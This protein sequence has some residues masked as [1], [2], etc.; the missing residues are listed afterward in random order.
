[1]NRDDLRWVWGCVL[2]VV[3]PSAVLHLATDPDRR[4]TGLTIAPFGW[5]RLLVAHLA[6][7]LPLGWLLAGRLLTAAGLRDVA[8]GMWVAAGVGGAGLAALVLPGV[9]EGLVVAEVGMVFALIL[10]TAI[11]VGLV[12]PWCLAFA[13]AEAPRLPP[14]LA[15]G[16]G[17]GLALVPC[18]V[19]TQAVITNRTE[20][21]QDRLERERLA[22]ARPVVLGLCEL[23]SDQPLGQSPPCQVLKNLNTILPRIERAV[24][25][26]LPPTA[27]PAARLQRATLLV[28][29]DR[30][31]EAA[32]LVA[33]HADTD[34]TAALLLAGIDRDR[35]RWADSDERYR[36][37]LAHFGPRATSDPNAAALCRVAYEGLAYNARQSGRPA[38]AR[39]ILEQGLA[40]L[41]AEAAFFHYQLGQHHAEGGRP[42]R[43]LHHLDE[44]I[45]LDPQRYGELAGRLRASLLPGPYGCTLP[46]LRPSSRPE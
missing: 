28:R 44:A 2:A 12:T 3:V 6:C 46:F 7:A 10:R 37:A 29:L 32:A 38:Q 33:P 22:A 25:R 16:L 15:T 42:R 17:L 5:P 30:L 11:A 13:P 40:E 20:L 45:R 43:A 19:Y 26:P 36:A 23:G 31:D 9:G 27:P 18:G 34:P 4:A 21:A 41:P 8:R 24:E 1:M 14:G 35:Q 39:Q